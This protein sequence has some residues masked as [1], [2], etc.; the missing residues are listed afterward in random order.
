M[1]HKSEG[2]FEFVGGNRT[3]VELEI[4]DQERQTLVLS[5]ESHLADLRTEIDD[6]DNGDYRKL[7]KAEKETLL[8]I[9]QTLQPSGKA[10]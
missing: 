4:T 8:R 9:L 3:M 10:V 1:M 7:L 6:T 2:R 5:I